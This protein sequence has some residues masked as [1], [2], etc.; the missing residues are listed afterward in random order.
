MSRTCWLIPFAL[1]LL[2]GCGGTA[3]RSSHGATA[4]V[5][6]SAPEPA[7]GAA[8]SASGGAA[9]NA[10]GSAGSNVAKSAGAAVDLQQRDIVRTATLDV[11]VSDVDRAA[12]AAVAATTAAGGRADADDRSTSGSDRH[13]HLVLRVPA[14][15]LTGL[16]DR[17][18]AGGHENS[19]TDH[20]DDVTAAKADVGARVA[21]LRISVARL[22]DFLRKS[23]SISE[24]VSLEDQLTQRQSELQS[25]I[26]QQNALADQVSLASLTV[27]LGA[28]L[29]PVARRTHSGPPGFGPAVIASLH[30][31]GATVRLLL[32][33]AGYL[34]PFLVLLV[35]I[36]FGLLWLRKRLRSGSPADPVADPS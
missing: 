10:S 16:L 7:A 34:V 14:A 27:D 33:G 31:L 17:V 28:T 29:P 36:G 1:V 12:D 5:A 21:E 2:A 15:G 6:Q 8:D 35:P 20:G 23:G 18:A 4:G 24:L 9:D 13:A 3:A 32:A 22:Q 11:T 19:R 25:T 26:A 30:G